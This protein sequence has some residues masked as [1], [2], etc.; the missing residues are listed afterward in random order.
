[1]TLTGSNLALNVDPAFKPSAGSTFVIV[2][3]NTGVT[4]TFKNLPNGTLLVINGLTYTLNY[5]TKQVVLTRTAANLKSAPMFDAGVD[6]S[7]DDKQR[8]MITRIQ[9]SYNTLV[10]ID[11]TAF[12][13]V[14]TSPGTGSANVKLTVN[15]VQDVLNNVT[16]VTITFAGGDTNTYARTYTVGS[17]TY[18]F[19]LNDGNYQLKVDGTK[20]IDNSGSAAASRADAFFRM[21]GDTD[22]NRSANA[23]D[24]TTF[25]RTQANNAV[26]AKYLAFLDY[27]GQSGVNNT[28]YTQF[29]TRYGRRLLP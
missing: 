11:P 17:N 27:D 20:I 13:V 6:D 16:N 1:V 26:Y 10:T 19:A 23:T 18:G 21:F 24:L 8:S 4:G 12:S 2:S 15:T 22:G 25:S 3:S 7:S 14:R 28:D 5:T 29:R 9:F